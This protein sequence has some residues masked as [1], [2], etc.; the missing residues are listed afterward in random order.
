MV[1]SRSSGV[2]VVV[3]LAFVAA[4]FGGGLLSHSQSSADANS[5]SSSFIALTIDEIIALSVVNCNTTTDPDPERLSIHI[6]PTAGTDT[7]GANCQNL[8]IATNT[9]GYTLAARSN[10]NDFTNNLTYQNPTTISPLPI[11]PSITSTATPSSPAVLTTN[12]WGF[13]VENHSGFDSSYSTNPSLIPSNKFANLPITDTTIADTNTMPASPDN[14]KFYY[15]AR[16]PAT[17]PAGTYTT[18]ITYTAVGKPV[19]PPLLSWKQISAGGDH[20]CGIAS[21]DWAYCWGGNWAGQLGD[22]TSNDSSTPVAVSQGVIPIGATIKQ[23]SAGA[24]HT[25]VIASNDLAYC[26]GNNGVGQLGDGTTNYSSTPVA[27]SQ[28]IIPT[29]ATIKQISASFD[30][31]CAIAGDDWAY[32]WGSDVLGSVVVSA[33]PMAVGQGAIPNSIGIKSI[34]TGGV[35]ACI[36]ASNDLAYC[37]GDNQSGQLGNNTFNDANVPVAVTGA[38]SGVAVKQIT[39]NFDFSG[40]TNS[41]CVIAVAGQAYCWGS[42]GY[43]QLGLGTVGA[44]QPTPQA[45]TGVLSGVVTKQISAGFLSVCAIADNNSQVYCWGNNWFGQLGDGTFD[46]S[47]IPVAV[48]GALSGVAVKQ[49]SSGGYFATEGSF[50]CAIAGSGQA[51][52]WGWNGSSAGDTIDSEVPVWVDVTGL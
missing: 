50:S 32:C 31:T 41:T 23:I 24:G 30:Y 5:S 17:K 1:K 43:G 12:A 47:P 45:V 13:A 15:A 51:Y 35:H 21:N 48:A 49:I 18:T 40:D 25:C 27:V 14:Y 2:L 22:G 4:V 36:I 6:A 44:S 29:G 42:N 37:W 34:S 10:S 38:L 33:A 28:G 19:P 39:T 7:Y 26:W 3:L 11:I 9:P 16:I 20:V 46:D 52:C 8:S